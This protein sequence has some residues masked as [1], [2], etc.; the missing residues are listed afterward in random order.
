MKLGSPLLIEI[1]SNPI[2]VYK[3]IV[4][5]NGD[6]AGSV[7][8]KFGGDVSMSKWRKGVVVQFKYMALLPGIKF[9]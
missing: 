8:L 4:E 5:I 7:E 6:V 3:G 9:R 1:M 2:S